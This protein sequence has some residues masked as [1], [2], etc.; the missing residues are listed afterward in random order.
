MQIWYSWECCL[1][2]LLQTESQKEIL[3]EHRQ[4]STQTSSRWHTETV[5]LT[6][7]VK[8][9]FNIKEYGH[10]MVFMS[11]GMVD[12]VV[13]S[14]E[15]NRAASSSSKPILISVQY[16]IVFKLPH[17]AIIDPFFL[18]LAQASG[19]NNGHVVR[20]QKGILS[21]FEERQNNCYPPRASRR[22]PLS[23]CGC[24]GTEERAERSPWKRLQ[25]K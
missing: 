7:G 13:N 10:N 4:R 19:V 22:I 15:N 11:K 8:Y 18:Q 23:I 20:V 16:P 5:V 25:E 24:R 6:G 9:I 21:W 1:E 2:A 14:G 17:Q 3:N 12:E